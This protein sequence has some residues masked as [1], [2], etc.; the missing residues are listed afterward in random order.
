MAEKTF[1]FKAASIGGEHNTIIIECE[2]KSD[3][4]SAASIG[5]GI[6][7]NA[8]QAQSLAQWLSFWLTPASTRVLKAQLD[9]MGY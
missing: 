9:R 1:K 3:D 7:E 2:G 6:R 8:E 4:M 5:E